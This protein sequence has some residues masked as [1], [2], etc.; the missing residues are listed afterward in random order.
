MTADG[1]LLGRTAIRKGSKGKESGGT[2]LGR[3]SSG[4]SPNT[5][6]ILTA[7]S[8]GRLG[9]EESRKLFTGYLHFSLRR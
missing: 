8:Y 7:S 9:G 5:G 1:A 3:R 6:G 4:K 2:G